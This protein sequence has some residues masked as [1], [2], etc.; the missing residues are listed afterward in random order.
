M[1]RW[2]PLLGKKFHHEFSGWLWV[3]LALS[4][5]WS[6]AQST[7][8]TSIIAIGLISNSILGAN[9]DGL[10]SRFK[11][12]KLLILPFWGLYLIQLVW[13]LGA[14]DYAEAGYI[15]GMR[16]GLLWMPLAYLMW[17]LDA[18]QFKRVAWAFI[19]SNLAVGLWMNRQGLIWLQDCPICYVEILGPQARP[20][21]A[22]YFC[23]AGLLALK[24]FSDSGKVERLLAGLS[25]TLLLSLCLGIYAKMSMLSFVLAAAVTVL[26]WFVQAKRWGPAIAGFFISLGLVSINGGLLVLL[27]QVK[28]SVE[29][30][31]SQTNAPW[32][33][34]ESFKVRLQ[35]WQVISQAID[36]HYLLGVG[37]GSLPTALH[38]LY[39]KVGISYCHYQYNPHN[40]YLEQWLQS[41]IT[42]LL[43]MTG[44]IGLLSFYG[45]RKRNP[46]LVFWALFF[47]FCLLTE[48]LLSREAGILLW[49]FTTYLVARDQDSNA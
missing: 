4:M 45:L 35:I 7:R 16:L 37:T 9:L 23:A 10:A 11:G 20:Y 24:L 19:V 26:I 28:S 13:S 47:A 25:S 33:I 18:V 8:Y 39:C 21:L 12:I 46:L 27:N 34:A 22:V 43:G 40:Q 14:T 6:Q 36:G 1:L 49:G 41:G 48:C 32:W 29:T 30:L 38:D 17:P 31:A 42:G 3:A 15:I 5:P 44:I 2:L